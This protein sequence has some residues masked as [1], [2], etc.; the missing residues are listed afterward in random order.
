MKKIKLLGLMLTYENHEVLDTWL[1]C[2]S[3]MFNKIFNL[4]GSNIYKNEI[5][6]LLKKHKV[7][8][9]HEDEFTNF[10]KTDH[11]LRSI[12]FNQI[13]NYINSDKDSLNNEYWIV[14]CHPDEFYTEPFIEIIK[15]ASRDNCTLI[16]ANNLHVCPL[17]NELQS[18]LE[19]KTFKIFNNFVYPGF[20]EKR[21]FK[22]EQYYTYE[23]NKHSSVV[24]INLQER[25]H[26]RHLNILHYKIINPEQ[27]ALIEAEWSRLTNHFPASHKFT[28]I[29]SFFL[30]APSGK[31]SH[32]ELL[33]KE[34]LIKDKLILRKLQLN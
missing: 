19:N 23:E 22:Y 34:D 28:S 10:S 1:D 8:N 14:L 30:D 27:H 16:N 4:D 18:W 32:H 17:K 3:S 29:D 26:Q 15:E 25:K 20:S 9:S 6:N 11:G 2:Y 21:I 31:Y 12:V 33:K 7:K 24:P 13:K 5:N